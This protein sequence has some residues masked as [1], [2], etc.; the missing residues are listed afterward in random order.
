M[1][2]NQ[3]LDEIL[4]R[5]TAEIRGEIIDNQTARE[6]ADR[7]W[8]RL[9]LESANANAQIDMKQAEHIENC[10]DFQSLIPAY[11]GGELNTSRALLLE[12]HTHECIP[13]RKALKLARTGQTSVAT[14][15]Q[16][17]KKQQTS[18]QPAVWKW[19]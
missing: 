16:F 14:V 17:K 6:A 9:S 7:V 12:D 3:E 13:C 4:D 5:A 11:L 19:A 18:V 8:A 1:K 10:A 15:S 2:R